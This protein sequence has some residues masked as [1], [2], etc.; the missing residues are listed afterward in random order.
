MNSLST[1]RLYC[2]MGSEIAADTAGPITKASPQAVPNRATPKAWFE[3]SDTSDI[4]AFDIGLTPTRR[5][6]YVHAQ[7]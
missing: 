7:N 4:I 6:P 3:L 2:P 1:V 5:K